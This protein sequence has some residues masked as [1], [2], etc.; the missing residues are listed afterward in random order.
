MEFGRLCKQVP[1]DEEQLTAV[2]CLLTPCSLQLV[3]LCRHVVLSDFAYRS[4]ELELGLKM[5]KPGL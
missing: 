2:L 3:L 4:P 1:G 5:L